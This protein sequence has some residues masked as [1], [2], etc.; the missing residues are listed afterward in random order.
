VLITCVCRTLEVFMTVVA[1][2]MQSFVIAYL[3]PDTGSDGSFAGPEDGGAVGFLST[4]VVA[5][6]TPE[7]RER[8]KR[9]AYLSAAV[10]TNIIVVLPGLYTACAVR[11]RPMFTQHKGCSIDCGGSRG[12]EDGSGG[13][14]LLAHRKTREDSA[15]E[16]A[17]E[18][19]RQ[20][21][22]I[23]TGLKAAWACKPYVLL[24]L[25]FLATWLS[26]QILAG[27]LVLYLDYAV[28]VYDQF[29]YILGT[30]MGS[31]VLWLLVFYQAMTR[32][33]LTKL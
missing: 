3:A 33:D 20:E 22:S 1:V 21:Q 26:F 9:V 2:V 18:R 19:E 17:D 29:E 24:N 10:L 5:P 16:E 13:P 25:T 27:N 7:E 30:V 31:T 32:Y 4:D 23:V 28:D 14:P 12:G 11:E 6:P 15:R 8:A